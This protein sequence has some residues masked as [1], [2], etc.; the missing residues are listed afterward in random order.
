[1]KS[2]AERIA[3][4]AM[5]TQQ[6]IQEELHTSIEQGLKEQ[7]IEERKKDIKI[8]ATERSSLVW[9]RILMSQLNSPFMIVL[10]VAA[11]IT[12]LLGDYS[13]ACMILICITV[14]TIFGF[15]QEYKAENSLKLLKK[16]LINK[17]TVLRDGQEREVAVT[18]LVLGDVLVLYPGDILPAD[19]RFVK[20]DHITIDESMITGE[21]VPVKKI[22]TPLKEQP[23][24]MF[25]AANIGFAGTTI[26]TGK[27]LGVIFAVGQDSSL[28]SLVTLTTDT[29][30][31]SSFSKNMATF[32]RFILYIIIAT[33]AAV[34]IVNLLIQGSSTDIVKLLVFAAALGISII[35]EALPVVTTFALTRGAVRLAKHEVVVKRISA[36]EDLGSIQVLCTDKTGTLTENVL[37][38]VGTFGLTPPELMMQAAIGSGIS[39]RK[40][41][42]TKGF[43]L[44]IYNAL[45]SAQ[46][47]ELALYSTVAELPF[48]PERRRSLVVIQ[49]GDMQELVVRG[50]PQEVLDCCKE[51]DEHKMKE[52]E[53]WLSAESDQ[54]CRLIALAS[55]KVSWS[56][57]SEIELKSL[58]HDLDLIGFIAFNDPL[59]PTAA[60]AVAK[61]RQLGIAIKI[62]SG[63]SVAVCTAIGSQIDLVRTGEEVI[64]GQDWAEL[65]EEQKERVV[66]EKTVFARV[67]PEQK[68][69]I[70][71]ELQKN[72]QVGYMGD[73]IN[74]APAL[75]IAHVALAVKDSADIARD[76]ADIILLH[77]SL[78]V[79]VNGIHEGRAIFANTL[80]YI[81]TTLSASFGHFYAL[82]LASLLVDY[83]PMLPIQLLLLNVMSDFPMIALSTDNVG[84]DEVQRPRSYD[85]K[86]LIILSTI[87][88]L[89]ITTFDFI[90]FG[91]L[92]K[93]APAV[94][95]TC[96]FMSCMFTEVAFIFSIRT[97]LPFYKAQAPSISLVAL[98]LAVVT[99]TLILPF[100]SFGQRFL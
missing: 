40:L 33:V 14:N 36:I 66:Q 72:Y 3:F 25:E 2:I 20:E 98:S 26:I 32:S 13:N 52:I 4:Y 42:Q 91:I 49:K 64:S 6:S 12:G 39:P 41:A 22:S 56:K 9:L 68:Y 30:R 55:K 51:L 38:V 46:K 86:G 95:Q 97:Q 45:T 16:Y 87:L 21:A 43:D 35:P 23:K 96:W 19:V 63:D 37:T 54:G 92:H 29:M 47:D 27:G 74:D 1:M 73:G 67:S 34:F 89:V 53:D 15:Y 75:K 82:A 84:I 10:L 93:Q 79:V 90:L 69:D 8:I 11:G 17:V 58:E 50:A 88:G 65:S 85:M 78:R 99:A 7:V 62:L 80:K 44:A 94:V 48:D 57:N 5:Q 59:K 24:G 76:A 77:Q 100:T 60:Y 61:A 31:I 81:K 28:G 71:K 18:E 83:L 70:I